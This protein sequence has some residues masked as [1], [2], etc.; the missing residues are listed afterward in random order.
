MNKIKKTIFL[1]SLLIFLFFSVGLVSQA[2]FVTNSPFS[3]K[4]SDDIENQIFFD[5]DLTFY[6]FEGEGCAC[7]P[8]V[9]ATFFAVG[10]EGNDSGVTDEDGKCVL[11]LVINSEY[12]I[13]IEA[14]K[15]HR[16]IFDIE[17]LDDQTFKFHMAKKEVSSVNINP[18]L[19]K[20]LTR[21]FNIDL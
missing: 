1:T 6:I 8:I 17:V 4:T 13:Y 19:Y 14:E 12:R 16:I 18:L 7:E 3:E 20:I 15:F 11:N 9:G 2:A 10:G 21:I 5:A